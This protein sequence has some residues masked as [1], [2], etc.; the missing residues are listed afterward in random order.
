LDDPDPVSS[1]SSFEGE[2]KDDNAMSVDGDVSYCGEEMEEL[3]EVTSPFKFKEANVSLH[4]IERREENVQSRKLLS[5]VSLQNNNEND[6]SNKD[7]SCNDS[8]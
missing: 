4:L 5:D 3:G 2:D 1:H 8:E 6:D 7:E